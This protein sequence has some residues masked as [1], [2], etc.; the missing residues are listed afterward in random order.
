M[1]KKLLGLIYVTLFSLAWAIQTIISKIAMNQGIDP[2][3]FS[4]QTLFA[5][6]IILLIYISITQFNDFKKITKVS[7]PKL[8]SI[9]ILGNGFATL[10]TFYG[11]KYSTSINYGFI[12]KST[13]I[14]SILLAYFFL[15][16][17]IN[18]KKIWLMI[19][20]LIGAY[21]ISTGGQTI[22]PKIGDLLILGAA[23]FL[24]AANIIARP[25]L[26]E[27]SPEI[28]SLF[29]T[30]SGGLVILLFSPFIIS[31]FFVVENFTLFLLRSIFVFLTLLFLNKTI[32]ATSISYMTMMSMMY[33]VFVAILGYLILNETMNFAQA[34]G[35]LL[36]IISVIFIQKSNN[37]NG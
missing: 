17:N 22:Y 21:L 19:V 20:L 10:L 27:Y 9:G 5:S 29:R 8:A 24:S 3:S 4:Y 36:I 18:S 35:G 2:I 14:F 13:L 6:A 23:F 30:M 31:Q 33:S 1:N 25:V 32:Q 37:L 34:I 16:E 7:I 11:L 28:V 15:K 12:V 26:K